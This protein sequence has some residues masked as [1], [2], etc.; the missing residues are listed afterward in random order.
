M[1]VK[2]PIS[3]DIFHKS[4]RRFWFWAFSYPPGSA[5]ALHPGLFDG[6]P[7]WG[8]FTSRTQISCNGL[9][10]TIK[11]NIAASFI[12]SIEYHLSVTSSAMQ[13]SEMKSRCNSQNRVLDFDCS[14]SLPHCGSSA[15][16]CESLFPFPRMAWGLG[17]ST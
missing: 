4:S 3:I 2:P 9:D 1:I 11:S 15:Q 8:S 17:T 6:H 16:I 13:R 12:R 14:H 10:L 7:R 5:K